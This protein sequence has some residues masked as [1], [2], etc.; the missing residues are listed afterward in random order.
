MKEEAI[1]LK[2]E[3]GLYGRVSIGRKCHFI[4]RKGQLCVMSIS[5]AKE[6]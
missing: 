6:M 3:V 5:R 1:D 2:E 4:V